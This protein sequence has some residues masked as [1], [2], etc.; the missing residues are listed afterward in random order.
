MKPAPFQYRAPGALAETLALLD[1]C[2]PDAKILA[3]G[4]SLIPVLNMRLAAPRYLIDINRVAGL[5]YM[6]DRKG[7]LAI[8]ALTRQRSVERAEIVRR[9]HPLLVEV[10]KYIGHM[11]IRN[12]GT[13]A[14]SIAH[15]DPAAE[16]PAL[17][18]CLD[19]EVVARN[20][21]GERVIGAD[22]LFT[23]HLTTSL[24]EGEILTEVR[25][26]WLTP[27]AGWSCIEF[28]RRSGDYALA[29]AIAIVCATSRGTCQSARISYF[30][31]APTPIRGHE[32]ERMLIGTTLDEATLQTA[33]RM[34]ESLVDDDFNDIHA[35]ATYRRALVAEATRRA[36]QI[37][38]HKT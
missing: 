25:F 34:A 13:I 37:A 23:D 36:L 26:P 20:S 2:G 12:R 38:W 29:G 16:L 31:I 33:A 21:S 28:A 9:R 15:A 30:G 4:Q 19:G 22:R 24:E 8:G 11:Q 35:T 3:G 18:T 7:Y 5:D 1:Q 6:E 32:I 10:I 14:G 17:L 27:Q